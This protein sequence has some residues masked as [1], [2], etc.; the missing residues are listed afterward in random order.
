MITEIYLLGIVTAA[1]IAEL[2]LFLYAKRSLK[3]GSDGG[4]RTDSEVLQGLKGRTDL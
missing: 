4:K 3:E 2:N 1:I